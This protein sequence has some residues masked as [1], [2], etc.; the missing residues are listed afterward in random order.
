VPSIGSPLKITLGI[1]V[2]L[3]THDTIRA[4]VLRRGDAKFD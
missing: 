4:A 2:L 3:G 1:A